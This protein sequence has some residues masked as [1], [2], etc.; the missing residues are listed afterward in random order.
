MADAK[1]R[2]ISRLSSSILECKIL[3][4]LQT[5]RRSRLHGRSAFKIA[6]RRAALAPASGLLLLRRRRQLG[7][8]F[9]VPGILGCST[10]SEKSSTGIRTRGHGVR[11]RAAIAASANF[12][13]A[14]GSGWPPFAQRAFLRVVQ[15]WP[16]S[17]ARAARASFVAAG[18]A[19]RRWRQTKSCPVHHPAKVGRS[20]VV[21]KAAA[22]GSQLFGG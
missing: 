3:M 17:F 14:L 2:Q 18:V 15:S 13:G 4:E 7:C 20:W 6:M 1:G 12:V 10:S 9:V 16:R 19:P 8:S 21:D 5:I 11:A 22:F